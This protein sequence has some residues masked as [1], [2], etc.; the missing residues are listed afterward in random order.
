MYTSLYLIP[1]RDFTIEN[2][3][4]SRWESTQ[5]KKDHAFIMDLIEKKGAGEDFLQ[6][7]FEQNKIPTIEHMHDL[8]GFQ[9]WTKEINFP[10]KDNF[11]NI[12]F[13]HSEFWHSKFRNGVWYCSLGFAR[14]Y[15][16]VFENMAFFFNNY[17]CS[18]LERV[19]FLN[20]NFFSHSSFT[21]CELI[22]A[23]FEN[24]HFDSVPFANCKFAGNTRFS[25]VRMVPVGGMPASRSELKKKNRCFIFQSISEGYRNG[26]QNRLAREFYYKQM[27]N[28][29]FYNLPPYQKPA[30]FLAMFVTGYG[31]LP[32]RI[33]LWLILMFSGNLLYFKQ[34][35]NASDSLIL[36]AGALFT[37]GAKTNLLDN[38]S[39][40]GQLLYVFTSFAGI[41]LV[42]LLVSSFSNIWNRELD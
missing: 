4:R 12:D 11:E 20:C 13:S 32:F 10:Q 6:R 37:F 39:F 41:S 22:D 5:G 40:L 14:Q 2:N 27:S 21:N 24:C 7:D 29:T 8:R 18:T 9:I 34:F 1:N 3:C 28:Y 36:A 25:G 17:F 19:S 26:G 42:A 30:S 23:V 15:N 38:L 35:F 16:C 33:F 31:V